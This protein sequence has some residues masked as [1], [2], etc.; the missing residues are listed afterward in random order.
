MIVKMKQLEA[1][2]IEDCKQFNNRATW[3]FY[4]LAKD[5]WLTGYKAAREQ[6]GKNLEINVESGLYE[7]VNDIGNNMVEVEIASNQIGMGK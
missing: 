6:I 5:M 4:C 3:E 7:V 1:W 2:C